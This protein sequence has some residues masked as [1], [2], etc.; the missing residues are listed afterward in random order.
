MMM[1]SSRGDMVADRREK[2]VVGRK[3]REEDCCGKW[4]E[5]VQRRK[6]LAT[7]WPGRDDSRREQLQSAEERCC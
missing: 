1:Q 2:K 5:E 6:M 3:S 4:R 7:V